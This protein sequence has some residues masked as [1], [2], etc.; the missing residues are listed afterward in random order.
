MYNA[1]SLFWH[2]YCMY[3]YIYIYVYSLIM[4]IHVVTVVSLSCPLIDEIKSKGGSV[5]VHC[6][7]GISR[8]ATVCIAYLMQKKHMS[9]SDAYKFVQSKRP[10]ISP[11]LGFMGQLLIHQQNLQTLWSSSTMTIK[12]Q[13]TSTTSTITTSCTRPLVTNSVPLVSRG[14]LMD[15]SPLSSL[16]ETTV[17]QPQQGVPKMNSRSISLPG[18]TRRKS[19]EG[20]KL[21]LSDNHHSSSTGTRQISPCRVEAVKDSL[22][23]SLNLS[24]TCT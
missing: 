3:V 10:I 11:N 9:L 22:S 2:S 4:S 20:L 13:D 17:F 18:V 8:S 16:P 12:S 21:T 1:L 15:T 6:H 24:T 14:S 5:F 19:R 7:A 23:L